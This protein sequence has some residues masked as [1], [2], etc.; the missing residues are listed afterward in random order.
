MV[1]TSGPNEVL[2]RPLD[3]HDLCRQD[4]GGVGG[5]NA[6]GCACVDTDGLAD[7]ESL[8]RG[9]RRRKGLQQRCRRRGGGRGDGGWRGG[10]RNSDFEAGRSGE[11][12]CSIRLRGFL[13][14]TCRARGWGGRDPEIL[15][16]RQHDSKYLGELHTEATQMLEGH[17]G[18]HELSF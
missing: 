1:S 9:R 7:F 6:R 8:T 3:P 13:P 12:R 10:C 17:R 14:R 18:Q 11:V 2:V 5:S 15:Q 16:R 4:A